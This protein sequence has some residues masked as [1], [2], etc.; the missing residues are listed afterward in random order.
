[1]PVTFVLIGRLS[2]KAFATSVIKAAGARGT[3][4][5]P[6]LPS[7]KALKTVSTA[8]FKDSKKRVMPTSVIVTS[9]LFLI[10]S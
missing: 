3:I 5:S 2:I 1:M 10:W 7:V 9:T 6:A 8:W 4:I